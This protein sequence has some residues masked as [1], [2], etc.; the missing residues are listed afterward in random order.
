MTRL[1]KLLTIVMMFS[2]LSSTLASAQMFEGPGQER[3]G[4]PMGNFEERP[5]VRMEGGI[6]IY[7]NQMGGQGMMEQVM[8]GELTEQEMRSK[9]Q[10]MTGAEFNEKGFQEWMNKVKERMKRED[11]VSY[12]HEGFDRGYSAGPSYEG[13]SKEHMIYGMV[14]QFISDDM[15]PS[16]IKQHCD[17]PSKIADTV[18]TKL[19]EKVGDLSSVCGRIGEQESRCEA[20]VKKGCSQ[21]GTPV[22]REGAAELEKLN[23]VGYSCPPNPDA[24]KA[25]CKLRSAKYREHNLQN[26]DEA[27]RQRFDFAG[28]RLAR[29]CDKFRQGQQCDE[30]AYLKRC[31]ESY[32]ATDDSSESSGPGFGGEQREQGEQRNICPMPAVLPQCGDGSAVRP[33][34]DSRGCASYS[35]EK[36]VSSC[37]PADVQACADGALRKKAD[38]KGCVSYY[39]DSSGS[40]DSP[41]PALTMPAC[42]QGMMVEKKSD[43]K[44][45]VY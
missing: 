29:E 7:K 32:G 3:E 33:M 17:D 40:S 9:F 41:C 35:C 15:D 43:E 34:I 6:T 39:C 24:I 5:D 19:K 45:C 38:E 10:E 37:P 8:R 21:I 26:L 13:Y 11:S 2:L 28:D 22:V 1:L 23:A 12:E 36:I 44:G 31:M 25:A 14:F 16:E 42:A 30:G 27:C 18:I 20:E 4:Q